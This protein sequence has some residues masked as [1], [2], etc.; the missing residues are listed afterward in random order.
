MEHMSFITIAYGTQV[1]TC[2]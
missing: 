2:K 1:K